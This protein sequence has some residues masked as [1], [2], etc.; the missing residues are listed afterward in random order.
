MGVGVLCLGIVGFVASRAPRPVVFEGKSVRAWSF[1]LYGPIEREKAQAVIQELGERAVPDLIRMLRTKDPMLARVVY[2]PPDWLPRPLQMLIRRTVRPADAS[3][4]RLVAANAA[5]TLGPKAAPASPALGVLLS[6][7]NL[8][9]RW[10]AARAL[11]R[12]A[13]EQAIQ[14]CQTILRGT[15]LDLHHPAI[16]ALGEMGTNALPA[17]PEVAAC[18]SH[19]HEVVRE[20]A[21]YTL[22]QMGNPALDRVLG[23]VRTSRGVERRTA[24]RTLQRLWPSPRIAVP[25]LLLM[26]QDPDAQNRIQAL[27]VLSTM[28]PSRKEVTAALTNLTSDPDDNVRT[29]AA[30]ALANQSLLSPKP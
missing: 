17:L 3:A 5:A 9:E 13:D 12:I 7:S 14:I 21:A 11:G 26:L 8:D 25:P 2:P 10:A 28:A 6:G 27:E 16:Y 4:C 23:L 24:A 18:L 20:S 15:N 19:P 22:G 30:T 1:Q 29:A